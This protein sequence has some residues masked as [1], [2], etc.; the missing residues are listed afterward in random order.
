MDPVF[1]AA[2]QCT[3]R[4]VFGLNTNTSSIGR[5]RLEGDKDVGDDYRK[6]RREVSKTANQINGYNAHGK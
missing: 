4:H 2:A 1:D 6:Q 3:L 5:E